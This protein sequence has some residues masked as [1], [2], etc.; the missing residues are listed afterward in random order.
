MNCLEK[1]GMKIFME[2]FFD[3]NDE[4]LKDV[5]D[6]LNLEYEYFNSG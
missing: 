4:Q 5:L 1:E 3:M 2:N 6:N